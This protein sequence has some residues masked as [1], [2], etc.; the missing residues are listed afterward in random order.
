MVTR[1]SGFDFSHDIL[2]LGDYEAMPVT[3][4]LLP[5]PCNYPEVVC[6][7]M[8][9]NVK[10]LK[11]DFLEFNKESNYFKSRAKFFKN[12]FRET[13]KLFEDIGFHKKTYQAYSLRKIG[14]NILLNNVGLYTKNFLNSL[15]IVLFRQQYVVAK[16]GWNTKL[17]IDHPNF[18]IHGYRLLIPI[19]TAF[20]GFERNIYLLEP[21]DCYFVNIAR[22]HRGFS[23]YKERAVIMCQ[24][25]SDSLILF[26]KK[27][28][29]I[30]NDSIPKEFRNAP[31]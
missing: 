22:K 1:L 10:S 18:K 31:I 30:S 24:M 28:K 11:R 20:I 26:G 27:V 6:L 13:V 17:H 29:P 7:N 3:S 4:T 19:D 8:K 15:N 25:A 21:G 5:Y 2:P 16:K 9:T 23:F 12:S 14:T